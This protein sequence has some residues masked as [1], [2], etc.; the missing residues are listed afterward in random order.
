MLNAYAT[1]CYV[2]IHLQHPCTATQLFAKL[3]ETRRELQATM[4]RLQ[5]LELQE[6]GLKLQINAM[7]LPA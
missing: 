1:M 3:T 6:E 7:G 5:N 2:P 4:L